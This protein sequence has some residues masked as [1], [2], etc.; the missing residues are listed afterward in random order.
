MKAILITLAMLALCTQVLAESISINAQTA[1]N[2]IEVPSGCFSLARKVPV[3]YR[4]DSLSYQLS[5]TPNELN[6]YWS[7]D[8]YCVGDEIVV[9]RPI[10]TN[11]GNVFILAK[12]LILN[13]KINTRFYRQVKREYWSADNEEFSKVL[14]ADNT[15]QWFS[16]TEIEASKKTDKDYGINKVIAYFNRVLGCKKNCISRSEIGELVPRKPDG[17]TPLMKL[18]GTAGP[19]FGLTPNEFFNGFNAPTP[20]NS[21]AYSSGSVYLHFERIEISAKF[22]NETLFDLSGADGGLGGL[23]LPMSCTNWRIQGGDVTLSCISG[24]YS[25]GY[26]T[27]YSGKGSSGAN[28][29]SL[30]L[31]KVVGPRLEEIKRMAN[32]SGGNSGNVTKTLTPYFEY[33]SERGPEVVGSYDGL[34]NGDDGEVSVRSLERGQLFADFMQLASTNF[35]LRDYSPLELAYRAKT[36]QQ[37]RNS[38][39]SDFVSEKVS[40]EYRRVLSMYVRQI[41]SFIYTGEIVHNETETSLFCGGLKPSNYREV[42]YILMQSVCES[43]GRIKNVIAYFDGTGGVFN[44]Q[45]KNTPENVRLDDISI[46]IVESKEVWSEM[47]SALYSQESRLIDIYGSVDSLRIESKI[48]EIKERLDALREK[49]NELENSEISDFE[50][51]VE[52]GMVIGGVNSAVGAAEG[53]SSAFKILSKANYKEEET[54]EIK[55]YTDEQKLEQA[56]DLYDEGSKLVKSLGKIK[57]SVDRL[58]EDNSEYS[59]YV[60]AQIEDSVREIDRLT[61]DLV[62]ISQYVSSEKDKVVSRYEYWLMKKLEDRRKFHSFS[63]ASIR[64]IPDYMRG[65]IILYMGSSSVDEVNILANLKGLEKYINEYPRQA[66]YIRMPSFEYNCKEVVNMKTDSFSYTHHPKGIDCLATPDV[67][68][69]YRV[70][71]EVLS[72]DGSKVEVPIY[73]VTNNFNSSFLPAFGLKRLKI[74]RIY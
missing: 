15:N 49:K 28:A 36:D 48:S 35:S 27:G 53:I 67:S 74:D 69:D 11:G 51:V 18:P 29:G 10:Y 71:A 60:Q 34:K 57:D 3:S 63:D 23:G 58:T 19:G 24:E 44:L 70:L 2:L 59:H 1:H 68:Y 64:N 9:D 4:P 41:E 14:S 39:L 42:S 17:L 5:R 50:A 54:N 25:S 26:K 62:Q 38:N 45:V 7:Y 52:I 66:F 32:L 31:A 61:E 22:N 40:N 47:I 73:T 13:S 33:A 55:A 56:G 8:I 12:K 20:V 30:Y 6:S 72:I 16:L 21:N 43:N 46:N 37:V 65:I